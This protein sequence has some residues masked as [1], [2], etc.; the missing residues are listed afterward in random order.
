MIALKE[1]PTSTYDSYFQA[2]LDTIVS[3]QDYLTLL[4]NSHHSNLE[5]ISDLQ[6]PLESRYAPGK[7]S[8]GQVIQHCID[9]ERV[10]CYRALAFMRGDKNALPGFDQDLYA[11]ITGGTAFAKAE[12]LKSM[13]ATRHSTIDLFENATQDSLQFLGNGNGKN[14]AAIAIPFIVCGQA[15]NSTLF[16]YR[17]CFLLP[18]FGIYEG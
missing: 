4:R 9:T 1:L 15:G 12:L 5:Y 18:C 2:Y 16:R 6:K 8:V 3:D 17:A 11:Q 13:A 7:W 14:M 10:F